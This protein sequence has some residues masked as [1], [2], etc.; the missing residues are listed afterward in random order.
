MNARTGSTVGALVALAAFGVATTCS[1]T[2]ATTAPPMYLSAA[3]RCSGGTWS[4]INDAAHSPYGVTGVTSTSA[5]VRVAHAHIDHVGSVQ[6]TADETYAQADVVVGASVGLDY[7][8]LRFA[9]A[10]VAV[11][12]S[13]LCTAYSNV[14]LTGWG[15]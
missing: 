7:V 8:E 11:N 12:P 2:T 15:E 1:A 3:V 14:W 13:T 9:K 5:Y 6:A 10:G 4:A